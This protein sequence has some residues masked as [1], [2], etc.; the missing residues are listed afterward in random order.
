MSQFISY[1]GVLNDGNLV[2]IVCVLTVIQYKKL[3]SRFTV[4]IQ[5][6]MYRVTIARQ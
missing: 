3:H 6:I 4:I 5:Y 2:I 1:Y